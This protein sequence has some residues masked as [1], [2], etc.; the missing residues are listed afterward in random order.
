[1]DQI[2]HTILGCS[3]KRGF[4]EDLLDPHWSPVHHLVNLLVHWRHDCNNLL[5]M[6]GAPFDSGALRRRTPQQILQVLRSISRCQ[7]HR[8]A[9]L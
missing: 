2:I 5:K 4:M 9:L 1:M 6:F 3:D 8:A 7:C